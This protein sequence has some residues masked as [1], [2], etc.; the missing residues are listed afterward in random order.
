MRWKWNDME[1]AKKRGRKE[2]GK[3]RGDHKEIVSNIIRE[4]FGQKKEK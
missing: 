2:E 3:I 1:M 4:D